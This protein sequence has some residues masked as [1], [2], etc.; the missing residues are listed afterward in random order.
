[1]RFL[2]KKPVPK[3]RFVPRPIPGVWAEVHRAAERKHAAMERAF[4]ETMEEAATRLSVPKMTA[5]LKRN[6]WRSAVGQFN[7]DLWRSAYEEQVLPLEYEIM[8]AG[9]RAAL[10]TI[11]GFVKA[12]PPGEGE[13][14]VGGF[15]DLSNPAAVKAAALNAAELVTNITMATQAALR[16]VIRQAQLDGLS[17]SR[18]A[19][20]IA[21]RLK[22]GV[23]LTRP[24]VIALSNLRR[25]WEVSGMSDAGMARLGREARTRMIGQR[26]LVIARHET[27]LAANTGVDEL[28]R[29]AVEEGH[30]KKGVM[31][32]WLAQPPLNEMNPCKICRPMDGQKRK[33]GEPF[34]SPYNGQTP[35]RPPMHI[36]CMCVAVLVDL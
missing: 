17:V 31:R 28:W 18:Q 5:A 7:R 24:Q 21:R 20:E 2:A 16:E 34:R 15:F 32:E 26:S 10:P 8:A 27:N 12:G 14:T 19:R 6:D 1:M 33:L 30:L 11:P 23:G 29:S 22:Q 35:L 3:L 25:S 4:R 13:L 36:T 9:A